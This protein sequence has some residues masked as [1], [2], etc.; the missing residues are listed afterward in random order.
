MDTINNNNDFS[1]EI[2]YTFKIDPSQFDDPMKTDKEINWKKFVA[3]N[4]ELS[5][6]T[7]VSKNLV[8]R[9]LKAQYPDSQCSMRKLI[10]AISQLEMSSDYKISYDKGR[11]NKKDG[12]RGI[13]IGLHS[14]Y[15][16]DNRLL[17]RDLEYETRVLNS[18][19]RI[20]KL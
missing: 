19:H 11:R 7:F 9:L 2:S 4:F 14:I 6:I 18:N 8:M 3:T 13:F 5:K 20:T 15:E 1:S 17:I 10:E 12:N 16:R